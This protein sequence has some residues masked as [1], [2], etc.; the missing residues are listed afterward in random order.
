MLDKSISL[1]YSLG[2]YSNEII[3]Q[4]KKEYDT[5]SENSK[6]ERKTLKVYTTWLLKNS[7]FILLGF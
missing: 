2:M 7:K 4:H 1:P 6:I 5:Y 3:N